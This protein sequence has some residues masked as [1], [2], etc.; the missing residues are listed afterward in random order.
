MPPSLTG[1]RW[2]LLPLDPALPLRTDVPP[3]TAPTIEA[4]LRAA[5]EGTA[6]S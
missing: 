2:S 5:W 3:V 6:A 1:A 4:L